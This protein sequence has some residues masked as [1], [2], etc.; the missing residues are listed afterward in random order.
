MSI[1]PPPGPQQPPTP[2]PQGAYGPQ[3][4]YGP[5]YRPWTQG[6]SPYNRP[7]P[8]N[9]LAIASLVFGVLCCVP[10]V[11]LVLGPLALRRIRRRGERGTGLAVGGT[12]LSAIGLVLWALILA[13]GGASAF[14]QGV[15]EGARD[16][17]S[18]TLVKGECFDAPGGRLAG[19]TRDV[20]VVPCSG[21]H[22]GEVFG[23]FR[24]KDGDYP[25]DASV[26][27]TAG[28]RCYGLRDGYAMDGWAVPDDVDVY[29]LTPTEESWS[30]G[31]RAVTCLFGSVTEGADLTGSLRNDET[32][33]DADQVAYL[34]AA[35]L[36][37]AAL[38]TAP[39]SARVEDDLSG[40]R[41]WAARMSAALDRQARLLRGRTWPAAAR[42]PVRSLAAAADRARAEWTRA[43]RAKDADA[44]HEHY[45]AGL[46]LLDPKAAVPARSAL[47]LAATPP[48]AARG[49]GGGAPDTPVGPDTTDAPSAA[50]T[51]V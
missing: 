5:P 21:G 22:D 32:V 27:D 11:G 7:A 44:F 51:E 12:V 2:Y 33:L 9:G 13:T 47:G 4:P 48:T 17:A 50:A 37:D 1:P 14:W 19:E 26:G 25:G 43:A 16:G 20:D 40:H 45:D 41:A 39:D 46:G 35:H 29:Y 23:S 42:R 8:V 28:A 34:K 6:Y 18:V 15:K 36:L 30:A 24:L 38:A 3:V 49:E 10:G 31:D